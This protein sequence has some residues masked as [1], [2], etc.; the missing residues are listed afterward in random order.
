MCA[1]GELDLVSKFGDN[2]RVKRPTGKQN[3]ASQ[4]CG[5]NVRPKFEKRKSKY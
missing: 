1:V 2:Q 4:L 5:I 3:L